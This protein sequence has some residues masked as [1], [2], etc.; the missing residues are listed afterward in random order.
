[1][2][3]FMNEVD[4]A[5][6]IGEVNWALRCSSKEIRALRKKG[7]KALLVALR[8]AAEIELTYADDTDMP[9]LVGAAK[10][11]AK[12]TEAEGATVSDF[13]SLAWAELLAFRTKKARA[14]FE[15]ALATKPKG[16]RKVLA[17]AVDWAASRKNAERLAALVEAAMKSDLDDCELAVRLLGQPDA[18]PVALADRLAETEGPVWDPIVARRTS[19]RVAM[20]RGQGRAKEAQAILDAWAK[21]C[22]RALPDPDDVRRHVL[23]HVGSDDALVRARRRID[24]V[25]RAFG[26]SHPALEQPLAQLASDARH[27]SA[28]EVAVDALRQ[29]DAFASKKGSSQ[30]ALLD[31]HLLLSKLRQGLVAL[32]RFDEA[33]EVLATEESVK[34]KRQLHLVPDHNARAMIHEA[35][36]DLDRMVE[37]HLLSV[38]QYEAGPPP[39]YGPDASNTRLARGWARQAMERAGRG[40]EGAR[41]FPRK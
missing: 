27:A 24:R 38:A 18:C 33:W 20:Y 3:A 21:A 15:A 26:A 17:A 8:R 16:S 4:A 25:A 7:G 28:H 29:L 31:R 23:D 22:E 6:S 37:E 40:A 35:Q 34:A 41:L 36:G 32:R 30:D 19:L 39:V 13:E 9:S 14:A 2:L 5:L 10:A 11:W 1:M 12:V